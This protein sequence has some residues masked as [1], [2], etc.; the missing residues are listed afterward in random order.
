MEKNK[1]VEIPK[2]SFNRSAELSSD[3]KEQ[4]IEYMEELTSEWPG[5]PLE[6][7]PEREAKIEQLLNNQTKWIENYLGLSVSRHLPHKEKIRFY[8]PD[9][10]RKIF[11][12]EKAEACTLF[13]SKEILS[14][15]IEGY[16]RSTLSTLNHELVHTLAGCTV[17]V[18][19]IPKEE[20]Y[21]LKFHEFRTG[22]CN[23][24]TKTFI[25]L[26][27]VVTEMLNIEM[28]DYMRKN[29]QMDDLLNG[30]NVS[31]HPAI[32]FFD[33]VIEKASSN[34]K[35]PGEELRKRLY[36]GYFLG[37]I[38]TLDFFEN[39]FG[40]G[41]LKILAGLRK[42]KFFQWEFYEDLCPNFGVDCEA[43]KNKL[44]CYETDREIEILGGIKLKRYL[45]PAI[46]E[47]ES[48]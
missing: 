38:K 22:Y 3:D 30:V 41:I 33:Q 21:S 9:E 32:L 4:I 31:F 19:K 2:Y 48:K 34:L 37:D 23:V 43:F 16:E 1:S 11:P 26:N 45:L 27:E 5:Q 36:K 18:E 47:N 12:D 15:D 35:I 14:S 17:F 7:T 42:D 8:S 6:I 25:L 10:F 29:N 44:I 24:R 40:K 46:K 20:D 13:K 28:L 39:A